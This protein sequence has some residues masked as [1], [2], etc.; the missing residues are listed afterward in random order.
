[1]EF[2]Q[3]LE[4]IVDGFNKILESI[5]G[6]FEDLG[7]LVSLTGN[8]VLRIPSYFTWLPDEVAQIFILGFSIVVVYKILG[9]EG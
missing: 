2:Q 6:F 1:M 5:G 8:F 3:L 7:Y 9:R 4:T